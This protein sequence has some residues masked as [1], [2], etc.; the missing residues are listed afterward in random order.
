MI[1][2]AAA[3]SVVTFWQDCTEEQ[4]QEN[5]AKRSELVLR[6]ES[7]QTYLVQAHVFCQGARF[8]ELFVPS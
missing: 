6:F 4:A 7:P 2:S 8:H 3:D 1:V 5:E